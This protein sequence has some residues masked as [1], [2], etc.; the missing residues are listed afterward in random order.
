MIKPCFLHFLLQTMHEVMFE[1][2][3]ENNLLLDGLFYF[4]FLIIERK[5]MLNEFGNSKE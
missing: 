2:D 4:I 1:M 5:E 3:G